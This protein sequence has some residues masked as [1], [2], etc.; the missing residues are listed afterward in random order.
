MNYSR[1]HILKYTI[2]HQMH[3]VKKQLIITCSGGAFRELSRAELAKVTAADAL[4]HPNWQ[5][6]RK[7]TVDSATL[8]NKGLEVLGIEGAW[9]RVRASSGELLPPQAQ[10]ARVRA[11]TT[12]PARVLVSVLFMLGTL[13]S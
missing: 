5:M 9:A 11:S 12:A 2:T 13:L 4:R 10:R 1:V 8:V 7:I 3:F 6:G